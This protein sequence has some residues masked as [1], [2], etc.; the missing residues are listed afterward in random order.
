MSKYLLLVLCAALTGCVA[1]PYGRANYYDY[2]P[3]YPNTYYS[4]TPAVTPVTIISHRHPY[5]YTPYP[6]YVEHGYYHGP[7]IVREH[8]RV[9]Y[10]REHEIRHHG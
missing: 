8:T 5:I 4:Y 9:R 6:Y 1:Y 2:P 7:V 3:A 10:V